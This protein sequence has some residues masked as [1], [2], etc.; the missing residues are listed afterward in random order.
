MFHVL[1]D[2]SALEDKC[3]EEV[4]Q[5]LGP[6]A[7]PAEGDLKSLNYLEA[8]FLE[9]IRLNPP[10]GADTKYCVK[11]PSFPDGPFI[12]AGTICV[13][14]PYSLNRLTQIWGDDAE[15]LKVDRWLDEDGHVK[16][17]SAFKYPTF[18]A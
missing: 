8:T 10:V 11:D 6:S 9:T 17:P 4:L 18:N 12:P 5:V 13:Y 7:D 2:H 3:F 14:S 16:Q 1:S 15:E